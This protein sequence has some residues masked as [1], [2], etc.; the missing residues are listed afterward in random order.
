[1]SLDS[2]ERGA[3]V[4]RIGGRSKHGVRKG[5]RRAHQVVKALGHAVMM[6]DGSAAC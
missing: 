4:E 5:P 3:R 1:V 2:I 6:A